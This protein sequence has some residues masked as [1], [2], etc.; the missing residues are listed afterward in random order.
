MFSMFDVASVKPDYR[1]KEAREYV[2]KHNSDW[3]KARMRVKPIMPWK[4][5]ISVV[6]KILPS[7]AELVAGCTENAYGQIHSHGFL[8][9]WH[10][11][12]YYHNIGIHAGKRGSRYSKTLKEFCQVFWNTRNGIE[13]PL[14]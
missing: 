5:S 1:G 9:G 3:Y 13:S 14:D 7:V 8:L 11:G 4:S 12:E 10:D 6:E 2:P